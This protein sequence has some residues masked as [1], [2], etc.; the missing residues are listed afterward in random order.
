MHPISINLL[1]LFLFWN[2]LHNVSMD[3][4][5]KISRTASLLMDVTFPVYI[6]IC[7]EIEY[8]SCVWNII[9]SLYVGHMLS[10]A[11][12]LNHS[13]TPATHCHMW[14]DFEGGW[15]IWQR[16]ADSEMADVRVWVNS[17]IFIISTLLQ[18]HFEIKDLK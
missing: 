14:A 7:S 18:N 4:L 2:S 13:A 10:R 16:W 9:S 5:H 15:Q 8:L 17:F 11:R 12:S 1:L 3:I 6:H